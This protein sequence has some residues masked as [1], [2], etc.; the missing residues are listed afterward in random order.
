MPKVYLL[1]AQSLLA[2]EP[3]NGCGKVIGDK[4]EATVHLEEYQKVIRNLNEMTEE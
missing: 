2:R 1:E 3:A 4:E